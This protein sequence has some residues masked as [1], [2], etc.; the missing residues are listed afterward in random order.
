ML[1]IRYSAR[2]VARLA[3]FAAFAA[4]AMPGVAAAQTF[5]ELAGKLGEARRVAATDSTRAIALADSA[6]AGVPD[7]PQFVYSH[8][9]T[10]AR[11]GRTKEA[12]A[13]VLPAPPRV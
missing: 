6:L 10:M 2:G 8:A 5:G 3:A 13:G 12:A 11:V 1:S 4:L 7:H 9:I